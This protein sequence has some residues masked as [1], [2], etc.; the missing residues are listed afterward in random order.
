MAGS[1]TSS[2][3][4]NALLAILVDVDEGRKRVLLIAACILAARKHSQWDG[5][6]SPGSELSFRMRLLWRK[7]L[8][9][10]L[11]HIGQLGQEDD[12]ATMRW[13]EIIDLYDWKARLI[14]TE[15]IL[16]PLFWP[17]TTSTQQN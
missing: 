17:S 5:R 1:F 7:E 16:L 8:W 12:G 3:L 6:H 11:I 9:R 2:V 14:P 4:G 10:R 13:Q 15:I